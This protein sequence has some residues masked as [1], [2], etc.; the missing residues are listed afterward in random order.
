MIATSIASAG[1]S[2]LTGI[3][4]GTARLQN[5]ASTIARD[6]VPVDAVVDT[7]IAEQEIRANAAVLRTVDDVTRHAVDILA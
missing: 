1:H 7:K 4:R 6:G 2:A 3:E 5:A